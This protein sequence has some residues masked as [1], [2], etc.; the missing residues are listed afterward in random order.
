M[1]G[2]LSG[3][4]S[5]RIFGNASTTSSASRSSAVGLRISSRSCCSGISAVG[6][7]SLGC[8]GRVGGP[9]L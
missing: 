5:G 1:I 6:R 4:A 3:V 9:R 7:R 8:G 2:K